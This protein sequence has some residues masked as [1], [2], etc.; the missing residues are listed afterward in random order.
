[1]PSEIRFHKLAGFIHQFMGIWGG[2][3]I[4]LF[5]FIYSGSDTILIYLFIYLLIYLFDRKNPV[6]FKPA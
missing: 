1:M 2:G 5:Y 4:Y 6:N 3:G